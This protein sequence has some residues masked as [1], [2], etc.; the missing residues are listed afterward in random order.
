MGM[1]MGELAFDTDGSLTVEGMNRLLPF[2]YRGDTTPAAYIEKMSVTD[3]GEQE[4]VRSF[5]A[6][7]LAWM[8]ANP[9][10]PGQSYDVGYV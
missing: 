10:Q 9:L 2:I 1:G 8:A 6:N 4:Q 7:T 5:W 3:P